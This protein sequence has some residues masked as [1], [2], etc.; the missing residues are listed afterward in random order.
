MNEVKKKLK[1]INVFFSNVFSQNVFE[2]AGDLI[3]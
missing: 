3:D 1:T 2:K